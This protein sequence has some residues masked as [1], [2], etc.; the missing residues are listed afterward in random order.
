MYEPFEGGAGSLL[1]FVI[2]LLVGLLFLYPLLL[3]PPSG[4]GMRPIEIPRT[5]SVLERLRRAKAL[6]ARS[7]SRRHRWRGFRSIWAAD[8]DP[9]NVSGE[10]DEFDRILSDRE[11]DEE[12]QEFNHR[13]FGRRRLV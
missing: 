2:M 3:I 9:L 7:R 8:D 10:S 4:D 11:E 13:V 12:D 6:E 5:S 1:Y